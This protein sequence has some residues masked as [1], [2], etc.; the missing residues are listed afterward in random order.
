[1]PRH[2]GKN[3]GKP[4]QRYQTEAPSQPESKSLAARRADFDDPKDGLKGK[5]G[6]HRPGSQR[7]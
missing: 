7:K 6:Y 2:D 4:R 5:P 1:M 3:Y